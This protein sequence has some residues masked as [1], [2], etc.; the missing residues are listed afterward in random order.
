[1]YQGDGCA[2]PNSVRA[3]NKLNWDRIRND[4]N[5]AS[6]N[7]SYCQVGYDLLGNGLRRN[8]IKIECSNL[9]IIL[10]IYDPNTNCEEE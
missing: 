5:F 3:I 7:R 6:R 2:D 8:D 9:N 4:L 1:M 10:K